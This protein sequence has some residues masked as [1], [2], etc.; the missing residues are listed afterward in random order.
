MVIAETH[1]DNRPV[2]E[3]DRIESLDVLRGF[4][5]LGILLLNIIGFGFVAAAYTSPGL[6]IED[7]N[8]LF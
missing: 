5:L 1:M 8:D 3:S 2:V 7:S 6:M 4:S